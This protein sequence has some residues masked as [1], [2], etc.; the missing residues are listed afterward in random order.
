MRVLVSVMPFT[1]HVRPISYFVAA[2]V[3]RGHPT[4]VYT[5]K[6]YRTRFERVGATVVQVSPSGLGSCPRS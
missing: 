2:L 1:G 6:R 4:T 3:A 5:G